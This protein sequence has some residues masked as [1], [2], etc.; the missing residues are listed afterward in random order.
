MSR[1]KHLNQRSQPC[2]TADCSDVENVGGGVG[3]GGAVAHGDI[4]PDPELCAVTAAAVRLITGL[5]C[6]TL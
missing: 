3:T 2:G 5:L 1:L 6:Y 4:R